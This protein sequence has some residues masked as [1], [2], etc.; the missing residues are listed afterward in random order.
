LFARKIGVDH[1]EKELYSVKSKRMKKK[2]EGKIGQKKNMRE[3]RRRRVKECLQ[4]DS[5]AGGTHDRRRRVKQRVH[6]KSR[7]GRQL[8]R[9]TSKRRDLSRSSTAKVRRRRGEPLGSREGLSKHEGSY[10]KYLRGRRSTARKRGAEKGAPMR[11]QIHR[12][13]SNVPE[14]A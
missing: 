7:P 12:I 13:P 14:P 6:L 8:N 5:S 1:E 11:V 10:M 9:R 2:N 4:L 3:V